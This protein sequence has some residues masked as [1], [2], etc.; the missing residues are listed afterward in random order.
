MNLYKRQ[1]KRTEI[2]VPLD[3]NLLISVGELSVRKNHKVVVDALQKLS[4]NYWYVIIGKGELKTELE[5]SDKTGR[6]KLLGYRT[7]V[8][9]LLHASDMF[10]FPS[11]QEGLPVALIE[12]MASGLP[13][14]ASKIRGNV[15]LIDELLFRP[16]D[17]IKIKEMIINTQ[18]KELG[19]RN[20]RKA[21]SFDIQITDRLICDI[22]ESER[23][24]S[25]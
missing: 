25:C 18:G 14:V 9:E 8:V 4:D 3:A 10:V 7:D 17:S 20:L 21:Q 6:L 12:A 23:N 5:N 22:Y 24:V 2:G 16:S 1:E 15:D 19:I 13:C 11:L